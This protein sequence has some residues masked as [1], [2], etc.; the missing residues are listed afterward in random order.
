[1]PGRIAAVAA[2]TVVLVAGCS[3]A[4]SPP[5]VTAS[6][7]YAG[8]PPAVAPYVDIVSGTADLSAIAAATG[9]KDYTLAFILADS[10]GSCTATWGGETALDDSTVTAGIAE[11]TALG[12]TPI[13][14]TGGAD[15]T[16]LESVCSAGI[17]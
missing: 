7:T 17:S 3:A 8:R 5:A 13:V 9:Q 14:S 10:A 1:M 6:P 16:Y 2:V 11:I 15:G 4:S 12:G